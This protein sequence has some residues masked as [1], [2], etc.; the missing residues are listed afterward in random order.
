MTNISF[1]LIL[2]YS[3]LAAAI[4]VLRLPESA[5]AEPEYKPAAGEAVPAE[6]VKCEWSKMDTAEYSECQKKKDYY[7]NISPQEK[8]EQ[9]REA[10]KARLIER[11]NDAEDRGWRG[12]AKHGGAR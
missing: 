9:N 6:E 2:L 5:L 11:A 1:R 3:L 4:T 8:R 12:A 10:I 7:Q